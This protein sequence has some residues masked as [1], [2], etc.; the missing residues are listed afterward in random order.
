M[1]ISTVYEKVNEQHEIYYP[2]QSG[3]LKEA[4]ASGQNSH[5]SDIDENKNIMTRY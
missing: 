5:P 3:S 4:N 2:A 1:G